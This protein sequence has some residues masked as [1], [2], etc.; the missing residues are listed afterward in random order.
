MHST[1]MAGRNNLAR[2]CGRQTRSK[3]LLLGCLFAAV[4]SVPAGAKDLQLAGKFAFPTD[5]NLEKASCVR[6]T[7]ATA[8]RLASSPYQ[9][10]RTPL[11]SG[12]TALLCSRPPGG[13]G[14]YMV[15]D[16]KAACDSERKD[17]ANAE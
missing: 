1:M 3:S 17:Q 14:G 7:Q 15:F 9:C 2:R 10:E 12:K 6:L 16:T 13:R 4:L 5:G 8:L 11:S